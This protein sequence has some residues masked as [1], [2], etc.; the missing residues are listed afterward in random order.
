MDIITII[1]LLA[2]TCTTTSFIPQIVKS[3]KTKNTKDLSLRMYLILAM[4]TLLWLIYGILNKS[5]PIIIANTI[6]LSFS[7]IILALK[8]KYK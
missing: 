7:L 1:G 6:V 4:G 2:A 8:F 5:L 3:V